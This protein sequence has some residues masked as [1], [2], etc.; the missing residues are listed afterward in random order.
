[1]KTPYAVIVPFHE[2]TYA[3]VR[4]LHKTPAKALAAAQEINQA[5]DAGGRYFAVELDAPAR[6]GDT[7]RW[8][9]HLT[10]IREAQ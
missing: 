10:L 5:L 7:I 9:L 3:T 4:S 1:M 8:R 6:V 2:G